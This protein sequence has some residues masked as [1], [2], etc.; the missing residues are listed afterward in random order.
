ML[1]DF[2]VTYEGRPLTL[3]CNTSTNATK[4]LQYLLYHN[5]KYI[6]R[7]KLIEILYS[8]SNISNP[9]NN[10]KVNIFRLRKLL[11]SSHLPEGNYIIFRSG[12]YSWDSD[13]EVEIDAFTF[14]QTAEEAA[15]FRK[16]A[17]ERCSLMI[18]AIDMYHGEFL[19]MAAT[20]PWV[21]FESVKYR[22][23][24]LACVKEVCQF[25]STSGK[26]EEALEICTKAA[27]IY[28]YEES[29]HLLR[30]SLLLDLHRYQDALAAYDEA[31]RRLLQDLGVTPSQDMIALYRRITG[32]I[33]HS[34]SVIEEVKATLSLDK[35]NDGAYYC[36]FPSFMDCYVFVSRLAERSGLSIF[37]M[38]CTL[39]NAHGVPLALGEKLNQAAADLEKCIYSSLRR[40]DLFTRYGPSQFLILLT[41]INS[42]NCN[43]VSD[44][45]NTQFHKLTDVR[46]VRIHHSFISGLDMNSKKE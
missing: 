24:Y 2:K 19:P 8:N 13:L 31:S 25:L 36:T 3:E 9:Q 39:T 44:R 38:L 4:L 34:L 23:I 40:S 46:G 43:I 30:I 35:P 16:S 22:D 5:G 32:N 29:I 33:R 37:L 17:D 12:M 41:G 21:A 10:L 11:Q 45:I 27:K 28:P 6:P 42:E 26:H 18:K 14:R 20:E 1:G 15:D 7:N